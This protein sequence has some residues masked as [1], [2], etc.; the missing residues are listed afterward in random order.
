MEK[1]LVRF[2]FTAP[3]RQRSYVEVECDTRNG[4]AELCHEGIWV[5]DSFYPPSMIQKATIL[6]PAKKG[7]FVI[8]S[9]PLPDREAEG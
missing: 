9:D 1:M 4:I 2:Y 6:P 3:I 8:E 7:G 5:K